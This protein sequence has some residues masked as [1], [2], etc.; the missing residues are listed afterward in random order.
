LVVASLLDGRCRLGVVSGNGLLFRFQAW[1]G[2]IRDLMHLVVP[3]KYV[4]R[5]R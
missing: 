4:K 3:H 2:K 5:L 1:E